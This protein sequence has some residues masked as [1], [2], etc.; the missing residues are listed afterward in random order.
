MF[1]NRPTLRPATDADSEALVSLIT[2]V[3]HE[4]GEVMFTEGADS[5]LLDLEARY[6]GRG[7]AFVVLEDEGGEIVGSH[8]TL[9]IEG[10]DGLLTFRRLY[11]DRSLRGSGLGKDLMDWAVDWS[12]ANSFRRVE[13]WSDTR[14]ETAHRFFERYGF[15][16]SGEVRDMDD[17]ALPYSE[18]FF[19]MD[20]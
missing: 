17:G 3:Y 4:Y 19:F 1:Q 16:R 6:A 13:F 5:D 10:R 2:A 14:F 8:A 20:L 7:G 18:Y 12:R 11:L 9:P 15:T